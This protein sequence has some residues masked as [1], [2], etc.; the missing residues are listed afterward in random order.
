MGVALRRLAFAAILLG[1]GAALVRYAFAGEGSPFVVFWFDRVFYSIVLLTV[2]GLIFARALRRDN[3][4]A[5]ICLGSAALCWSLGST[6][7]AI[8]L[9]ERNPM[10]YPSVADG[11]WMLFYPFAYA[12][13]LLLARTQLAH[14]RHTSWLDGA[15]GALGI[16]SV[17]AAVAFGTIVEGNV[18]VRNGSSRSIT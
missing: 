6:Y 12:G 17:G 18:A 8:F 10:P 9:W 15:I 11:L 3:R 5:W 7:Y 14:V 13:V 2:S 4:L 1:T 16:S